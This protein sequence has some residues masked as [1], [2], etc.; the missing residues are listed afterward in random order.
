MLTNNFT[1]YWEDYARYQFF[2]I[3]II[4]IIIITYYFVI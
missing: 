3:I 4:I 2:V 1:Y